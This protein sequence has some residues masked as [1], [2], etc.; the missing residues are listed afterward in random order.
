MW[1][2]A[3]LPF[4]REH[5]YI[6]VYAFGPEHGALQGPALTLSNLFSPGDLV[7]YPFEWVNAVVF[8]FVPKISGAFSFLNKS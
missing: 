3:P 8:L 7:K 2:P 6:Y 1:A 4:S 5:T